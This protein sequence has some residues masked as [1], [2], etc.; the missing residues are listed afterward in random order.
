VIATADARIKAA[1]LG[2][3]FFLT[4][5]GARTCNERSAARPHCRGHLVSL[6]MP[7]STR[8]GQV[9]TRLRRSPL[10]WRSMSISGEGRSHSRARRKPG[11]AARGYRGLRR[12]AGSR[13]LR[14]YEGRPARDGRGDHGHI[15]TEMSPG[16]RTTNEQVL[17]DRD[18]PA[19]L[20]R[21]LVI[22]GH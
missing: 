8:P 1:N 20:I 5:T 9:S 2:T 14:G 22:S 6:P 13:Q 19:L 10:C 18:C 16:C 21:T 15:E 7:P 12:R 17:A 4:G 11:H 3:A